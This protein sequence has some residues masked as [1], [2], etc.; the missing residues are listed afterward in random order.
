MEKGKKYFL[1]G[2]KKIK[3]MKGDIKALREL[4]IQACEL[5][6]FEHL[7]GVVERSH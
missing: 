3:E 6:E 2:K 4:A 7:S 1:L 5:G